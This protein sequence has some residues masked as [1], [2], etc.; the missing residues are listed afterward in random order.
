MA[1]ALFVN[2]GLQTQAEHSTEFPDITLPA[3]LHVFRAR[4]RGSRCFAAKGVTE[5]F[6]HRPDDRA[7]V[8]PARPGAAVSRGTS[9]RGMS[10]ARQAGDTLADAAKLAQA[11]DCLTET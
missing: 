5:R 8:Y 9:P 4:R 1:R 2:Y 6:C 7:D 10:L 3:I 11:R